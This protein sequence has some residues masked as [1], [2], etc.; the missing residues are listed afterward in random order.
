MRRASMTMP[1]CEVMRQLTTNGTDQEVAILMDV[2]NEV[3]FEQPYH[4]DDPECF[5][6]ATAALLLRYEEHLPLGATW[7]TIRDESAQ[8]VAASSG[9]ESGEP[10]LANIRRLH[11]FERSQQHR[12]MA[13]L[14]S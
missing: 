14:S 6:E 2:V 7:Q 11:A 5:W 3:L 9:S 8:K 13:A 4:R 12:I 1:V 10:V